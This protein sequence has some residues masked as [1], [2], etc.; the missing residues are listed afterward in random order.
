MIIQAFLIGLQRYEKPAIT[1]DV[2][3]YILPAFNFFFFFN[4]MAF[5]GFGKDIVLYFV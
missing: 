1:N 5:N 2:F 4:P 3:L